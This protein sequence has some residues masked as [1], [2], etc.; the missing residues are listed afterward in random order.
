MS[1]THFARYLVEIGACANT[2]EVFKKYLSEGKPGYVPH[3]WATLEQSVSW[4]RD[5]GGIAVIAHPGRYRF[6]QLAQG[7]LF[8]NSSSWAARPSRWSPAAIR[9]T[10]IRC[11]RS[12][13]ITTASWP[14]AAPTSMRRAN[15]RRFCSLAAAACQCDTGLARLVLSYQ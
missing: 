6:T 12:W 5:A 11:T 7:E 9:R 8:A 2:A 14:R 3:R 4:I 15:P 13:Q 10:S 1:R